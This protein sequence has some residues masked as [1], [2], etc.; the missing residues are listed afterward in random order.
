MSDKQFQQLLKK[1][2]T[3]QEFFVFAGLLV[4]SLVGIA[5]L[6]K[7]LISQAETPT[8]AKE[9]EA[10]TVNNPATK[11]T[12][13]TA[14]GGQAVKFGPP[15]APP[16]GFTLGTTK[17]GAANTGLNVLGLTT[18]D[19]TIINGDLN[20]TD[21]T[22]TSHG[23]T[24]WDKYWVKGHIVMTAT[25][26]VY[27]KN[28]LVQGRTF[29][30]GSPPYDAIVHARSTSKPATAVINFDNCKITCIQPDTYLSTAA[31]ERLG[32]FHR[33]DISLGSDGVDYWSPA[34]PNVEGSYFHDHTVWKNDSKHTS[35]GTHPGWSH[36]D[37]IQN[38]GSNGGHIKG[39][40]FDIHFNRQYGDYQTF[41]NGDG[42]GSFP[43]G[44][45][46]S[47]VILTSSGAHITNIAISYNWFNGGECQCFMP[48]QPG[49]YP[50]G[51]S[52]KVFN[53]RFTP[54]EHGYGSAPYLSMQAARVTIGIGASI[55]D[56][57]NNVWDPDAPSCKSTGLAGKACVMVANPSSNPT[58]Y[59]A[60]Y[61]SAT[62]LSN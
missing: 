36:N 30:V 18:A 19:L 49:N 43:N 17:P 8:A 24:T 52:W 48:K 59:L 37:F 7:E 25:Q 13:T 33:C 46:G 55:G 9:T 47:G 29:T 31:G 6:I 10:G 58:Q 14:S 35:D 15:V 22:I 45:Y 42:H 44:N 40:Y 2:M 1:D 41:I 26:P 27:I 39:N 54:N 4:A 60:S 12:D 23:S 34:V 57:Y 32:Y 56:F 61:T 16:T 62:Q 28:S 53:N 20:I 11:V 21:A 50:T 38:S 51:N 5:G 3:R